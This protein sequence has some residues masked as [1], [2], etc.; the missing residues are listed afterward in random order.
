MTAR[1]SGAA[2]KDAGASHARNMRKWVPY[3][4][5]IKLAVLHHSSIRHSVLKH[6][7]I[8]VLHHDIIRHSVL[9]AITSPVCIAAA[10]DTVC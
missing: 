10:S 1:P 9:A 4:N 3:C 8:S 2:E 6:S 7:T 5:A